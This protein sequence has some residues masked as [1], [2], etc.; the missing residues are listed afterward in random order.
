M[1]HHALALAVSIALSVHILIYTLLGL[2]PAPKQEITEKSI[3]V[4]LVSRAATSRESLSTTEQSTQEQA[5]SKT[6][7]TISESRYEAPSS[8][9]A[10]LTRNEE[11]KV[12]S[13]ND[14]KMP[15]R[16]SLQNQNRAN[17]ASIGSIFQSKQGELKEEIVVST[18]PVKHKM[19]DYEQSLLKHL[20]ESKLYDQFNRYML[21]SPTENISFQLELYLFANGAIRSAKLVEKDEDLDIDQLVVTATYN[22]SPYPRPPSED[23]DKNYRYTVNMSYK[24]DH[25]V[26]IN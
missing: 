25:F 1:S 18:K 20:L 12:S 19:S 24:K 13:S 23:A 10:D 3:P 4:T 6:L 5:P 7:A 22:A 26:E 17:T 11:N 8:K 2:W 15:S 16:S 21:S 14:T 9:E